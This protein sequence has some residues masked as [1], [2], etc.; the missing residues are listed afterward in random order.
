MRLLLIRHGQTPS[1]V[2][3]LLDSGAP[4][5]GL[6]RLG[7]RQA[8]AVPTALED[9]AIDG[10]AVSTLVRTHLTAEPLVS[11]RGLAP[12]ELD[13]LR[14]VQSGDLE[15]RSDRDSHIAYM[16]AALAWGAGDLDRRMPGGQDGH[17]FF[18]RYDSAVAEIA[19][20][21]W[22]TAV[23]FSHGAAIRVWVAGRASGVDAERIR[24]TPLDNTGLIEV[25]GDPESGWRFVRWADGPVGGA[26]L[27]RDDADDPTGEGIDD[28]AD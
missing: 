16:T 6:T 5:P 18:A 2:D 1:N 20:Q 15:M 14:E 19:A 25:E 22:E 12:I 8:E 17:E 28:L 23:A 10:I 9:V 13:G 24:D 4:G 7:H 26:H 21:G 3:G 27:T 11:A